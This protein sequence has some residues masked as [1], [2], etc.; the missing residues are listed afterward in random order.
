MKR[1]LVV[2]ALAS[3][4]RRDAPPVSTPTVADVL[5][6]PTPEALSILRLHSELAPKLVGA[7]RDDE[8]TI[9]AEDLLLAWGINALPY[10]KQA[11]AR[12]PAPSSDTI[13][14]IALEIAPKDQHREILFMALRNPHDG[15]K[16]HGAMNL[17]DDKS[18]EVLAALFVAYS[19]MAPRDPWSGF[20]VLRRDAN[21]QP[22]TFHGSGGPE[23]QIWLEML[24]LVGSD[25]DMVLRALTHKDPRVR[26][27]AAGGAYFW[28]EQYPKERV[29]IERA[30]ETASRDPDKAVRD[31]AVSVLQ[32]LR[33]QD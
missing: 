32:Q 16:V 19:E 4:C 7:L 9:R 5:R 25:I 18:D 30:L 22:V 21:G 33:G 6:K 11:V 31:L 1:L 23:H 8:S 3:A 20:V 29:R 13:I 14:R 17:V 15:V 10:L 28:C 24:D 26:I 27:G 2:L 12:G